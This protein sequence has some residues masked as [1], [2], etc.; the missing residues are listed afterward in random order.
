MDKLVDHVFYFTGD[1]EIKDIMGN[2]TAYHKARIT[3]QQEQAKAKITQSNA[4]AAAAK[5]PKP[6]ITANQEKQ[7]KLSFKEKLEFENIEQEI[8]DLEEKKEKLTQKL[9]D[10]SLAGDEM[11]A[12][13]MGLSEVVAQI[14]AKTERW[15]ALSDFQS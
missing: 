11:N 2:Y 14:D 12:I 6:E 5:V 4:A 10:T 13:S 3:I 8:A 9:Y 7:R 1:G 15:I